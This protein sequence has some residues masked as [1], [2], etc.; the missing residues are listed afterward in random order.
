MDLVEDSCLD[1]LGL[2]QRRGYLQKRLVGE[3]DRPL[4]H[5]PHRAGE[6]QATE[7]FEEGAG[8]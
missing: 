2:D 7:I 4:R 8:E 3:E 6:A 5:G 1:Q